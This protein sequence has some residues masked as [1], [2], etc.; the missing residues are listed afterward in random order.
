MVLIVAQLYSYGYY[1]INDG[2]AEIVLT[3]SE[4]K[5]GVL[6]NGIHAN[7]RVYHG[8]DLTNDVD[9]TMTGP[10][11]KIAKAVRH[12]NISQLARLKSR[13]ITLWKFKRD[14][15]NSQTYITPYIMGNFPP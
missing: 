3:T 13:L 8:W 4:I 14:A 11:L 5:V 12:T 1:S 9:V 2:A 6:I 7:Y 15:W 10:Q